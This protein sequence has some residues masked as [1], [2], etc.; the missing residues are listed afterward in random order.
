MMRSHAVQIKTSRISQA[1]FGKTPLQIANCLAFL[2][3]TDNFR[4]SQVNG[5]TILL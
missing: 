3:A 1:E 5:L 4:Q 2:W